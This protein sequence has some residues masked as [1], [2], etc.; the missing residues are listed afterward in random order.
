MRMRFRVT[1]EIVTPE[2]AEHGDVAD[3]GFL[4]AQGWRVEA[5]I[6]KPTP[7][8]NMTLREAANLVGCCE[9]AGSWLIETDG[10]D[11]YATGEHEW[12]SLHP[13]DNITAA[14]YERVARLF[15]A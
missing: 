14:S 1:Y 13:P 9:D 2:S 12:R 15:G 11:K 6:G 10:R 4:T 8:V 5:L 7:G 3:S